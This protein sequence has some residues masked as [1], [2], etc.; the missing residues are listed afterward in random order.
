MRQKIRIQDVAAAA[1]V[2]TQTV[3]RVLN[4]KP[5]V[6]HA[7]RQKILAAIHDLGYE[8]NLL[9]RGLASNRTHVLGLVTYDFSDPTFAAILAAAEREAREHDY[10]FLVAS[11]EFNAMDEAEILRLFVSHQVAGVIVTSQGRETDADIVSLL[12]KGMPVVDVSPFIRDNRI[13]GVTVNNLEGG[14]K[15]ARHLLELGH[16]HIAM[17][18]GPM[19]NMSS[20][21]R[22]EGFCKALDESGKPLNPQLIAHG[23]WDYPSG[24]LGLRE[25]MTH[26]I[27]FTGL[28]V[29]NDCMAIAAMEA[30]REVGYRIPEDVSVIGFDDTPEAS[31]SH[32]PLTTIRQSPQE[33]GRT[34]TRI[35]IDLIEHPEA[36]HDNITLPTDL[37]VRQSTC[38]QVS[39]AVS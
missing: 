9:A 31:F 39:Q 29:Q 19:D 5:Y 38:S 36:I 20:R 35:L 18:T 34:A 15:A 2:S 16:S 12:N 17:I 1:G 24:Y 13:P 28:F 7:T 33:I 3:S 32:P 11:S 21:E 27:R 23:N 4:K 26:E 6:T 10:F 30:L 25:L 37:V 22:M 14:Y 8:P